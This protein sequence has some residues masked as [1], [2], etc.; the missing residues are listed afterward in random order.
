MYVFISGDLWC[1]GI[2]VYVYGSSICLFKKE[3]FYNELI[4]VCIDDFYF[5]LIVWCDEV[6]GIRVFLMVGVGVEGLVI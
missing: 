6:I 2:Y 1:N 4:F 5:F 3:V